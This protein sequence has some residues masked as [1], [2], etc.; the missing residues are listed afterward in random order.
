VAG[1]IDTN[2][3]FF[4]VA[5]MTAVDLLGALAPRGIRFDR[6]G[7]HTLRAVTHLDVSRENIEEAAAAVAN[8]VL[9]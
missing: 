3:V 7:D 6:I 5:S 2:I 1:P 9:A 8:T 4:E